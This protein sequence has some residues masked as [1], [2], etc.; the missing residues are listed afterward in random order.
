MVNT[1]LLAQ[2]QASFCAL[3]E[4]PA[5]K[6]PL[7][8]IKRMLAVQPTNRPNSDECLRHV[9]RWSVLNYWGS[10]ATIQEHFV[11]VISY[12]SEV[13]PQMLQIAAALEQH[14]GRRTVCAIERFEPDAFRWCTDSCASQGGYGLTFTLSG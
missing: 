12:K 13:Q 2:G 6:D 5:M 11:I 14:F 1:F 7:Q 8:L 10:H 4:Q 3:D 9:E